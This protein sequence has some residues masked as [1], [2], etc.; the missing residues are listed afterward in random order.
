[1]PSHGSPRSAH[2][3][4]TAGR[5]NAAGS[6]PGTSAHVSG[7]ETRASWVGRT[8]QAEA[9]VRSK[10][11]WLKSTKTPWRSSFHQRAVAQVGRAPLALAR[12][13]LRGEPH[14]PER[15]LPLDPRVHVEAPAAR[16]LRPGRQP[17]LLEHVARQQGDL[18]DVLPGRP[19]HGV[20]VDPQLVG[21]REVVGEHRVRVEVDAAEVHGPGQAG[22]AVD[23]RLLRGGAGGVLSARRRRRRAA[24][25]RAR[26]S[27][28]TP[29]RRCP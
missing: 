18:D 16:R 13:G 20:E 1:M 21:V 23:H 24:A 7:V 6:Q 8:D 19:R 15:P 22:G 5:V 4:S 10:A 27:G 29:P 11:F 14:L 26:A 17:V 12:H 28:R 3:S 25:C 9:T 2:R